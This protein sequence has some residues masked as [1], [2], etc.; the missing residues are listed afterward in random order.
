MIESLDEFY[1]ANL[2]QEILR[3]MRESASRG[4]LVSSGTP[5]GYRRV[6][7][8]DGKAQRATL[9][10][11]SHTASLVAGMFRAALEGYGLKKIASDLNAQGIAAP[12][13]AR[14]GMTTVHK[15]LTDEAYVG[16]LVWGK[17]TKK[18]ESPPPIRVDGAW[19]ALVDGTTFDQVQILMHERAPT[20]TH[21]RRVASSY[22]LSGIAQCGACGKAMI[23]Q[24]AKSGM[25]S[26]YVCGTLMRR[27]DTPY[28][29]TQKFEG[30]I[31]DN[32]KERVLTKENL[33][34][35]VYLVQDEMDGV[36]SENRKRLES[37][38]RELD[39]VARRLERLYDALE[40]GKLSLE[41]LSP[42]IQQLRQ[43][44]D[45]LL[46]VQGEFEQMLINRKADVADL[47]LVTRY[48]EDLRELLT[49]GNLVE[50]KS[51]IRSFVKKVQVQRQE[52]VITYTLPLPPDQPDDDKTGVLAFIHDGGAEGN[53]TPDPLN[54]IEVLSL[55]ELQP[56]TAVKYSKCRW[57][58][59]GNLS[60]PGPTTR[61]PSPAQ[62]DILNRPH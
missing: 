55:A 49:T 23:G 37:V 20:I 11:D 33:E 58:A 15:I 18:A 40:T 4:Y 41:D 60:S 14:W 61:A 46:A 45:Q 25:F 35:L 52:A 2:A 39:D 32:I 50:Q 51:F 5:F 7:V 43:R 27:G 12:R 8:K 59:Q 47:T 17:T 3:G 13:S 24:P 9:E 44:Q 6:K 16:T 31:I 28:L 57:Q 29:N 62:I 19:P 42:R 48:A 36:T 56:H 53:R 10:P 34:K 30:F 26:Y 54:A 38:Q 22:L 1:S 21:P